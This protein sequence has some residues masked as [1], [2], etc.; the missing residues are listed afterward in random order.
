MPIP[1]DEQTLKNRIGELAALRCAT[2]S[3]DRYPDAA[4]E[5]G[6]RSA[7]AEL[8]SDETL[9]EAVLLASPVLATQTARVLGDDQS[10]TPLKKR[11]RIHKGL[12]KYALRLSTRCTPFGTFAG[13]TMLPFGTDEPV[14]AIEHRRHVLASRTLAR[15]LA[16]DVRAGRE[17]HL[18]TNPAVVSRGDRYV[19]AVMRGSDSTDDTA[20]V[21]ATGPATVAIEFA[22][23][24]QP[25]HRIEEQ[26]A[27]AY[28]DAPAAAVDGLVTQLV[29][30]EV[31]LSTADPSFFDVDPLDRVPDTAP[32]LAEIRRALHRYQVA[33][34]DTAFDELQTLLT[35]CGPG[36]ELQRDL[37]VDIELTASGSIPDSVRSAAGAV[38][39][40]LT[41]TT[42]STGQDPTLDD[43][44]DEF[45]ERYGHTL[46]PLLHVVDEELGIGFPRSY[47][48]PATAHNSRSAARAKQRDLRGRLLERARR[49]GTDTVHITDA[50]LDDLPEPDGL[51]S[52]YD[53]FLR[54]HRGPSGPAATVI[55]ANFPGGTAVGRFTPAI[56][57]AD[58]H[59]RR[60][61]DWDLRWWSTA[62]SGGDGIV[63]DIDYVCG[64][65]GVNEVAATGQVLPR[66]LVV[67]SDPGEDPERTLRLTDIHLGLAGD[68]VRLFLSDGTPLRCQQLNMVTVETSARVVRLLQDISNDGF[69]RPYW[70]WGELDTG[71]HFF[72]EVRYDGVVIAERRWRY[73]DTA[74]RTVPAVRAWLREAG[75]DRYILIGEFDNRLH[76][77]TEHPRH[78]DLL[79][80]QITKGQNWLHAGP[81]P[82]DLGV[83]RD[84]HDRWHA[85][86]V[87][88]T[89][90]SPMRPESRPSATEHPRFDPAADP[91][92][93]LVPGGDWTYLTIRI[94]PTQY[95]RVLTEFDRALPELRGRWYFVRYRDGG[96]GQLRIRI[97]RPVTDLG[98]AFEWL[99]EARL[100]GLIGEYALPMYHREI[101]RYGG[102]RSH[103][104]YESFFC[105]ETSAII[106]LLPVIST[107]QRKPV[108]Q[109]DQLRPGIEQ[110]A[111]IVNRWLTGLAC[112][113][114][115]IHATVDLAV[116]GYRGELGD[117]A[118]EIKKKLRGSVIAD[119]AAYA[120]TVPEAREF[121][122]RNHRAATRT[123]DILQSASHMLCNRIGLT[124]AEEFAVMW[125]IKGEFDAEGRGRVAG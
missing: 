102:A 40:L 55:G 80:D 34:A 33:R 69:V 51:A 28:P 123:P 95:D 78:L 77:D 9:R 111:G 15:R 35:D 68:R 30:A 109:H 41:R 99:A 107:E 24:P 76:L 70:S 48:Q 66:T 26:L 18:F 71:M 52:G 63:V 74:Q 85:A 91:Q 56:A 114:E 73:P 65:D 116:T 50:D 16:Q 57:S 17:A 12:L 124:R 110:A 19:I 31:L 100:S 92:R 115:L 105:L 121:W 25:R 54:L 104:I 82:T 97:H 27:R 37:H 58:L 87:V 43:F 72:P 20:S 45:R 49:L 13:M 3:V 112:A 39:R 6:D 84:E 22:I 93:L 79:A 1:D 2:G 4:A 119:N 113:D 38:V 36:G 117:T 21:R 42:L 120:G 64:R 10:A 7:I 11:R 47:A 86:E 53:I 32:G 83:V 101:E 60:C 118:H 44:C 14:L 46:V 122:A 125:M 67:N 59:L 96:T 108:T 81:A 106:P 8:W 61:A 90:A 94:D 75:V 98:G 88:V 103:A 62:A 29:D 23:R 89:V 5:W